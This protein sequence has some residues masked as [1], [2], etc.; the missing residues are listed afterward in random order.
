MEHVV[1]TLVSLKCCLER[2]H[3]SLLREVMDYFSELMKANKEE[4]RDAMG[5]DPTL[6]HE[7]EYDL[8]QYEKEFAAKQQQ[9]QQS[10]VNNLLPH[11]LKDHQ[12][13]CAASEKLFFVV[14]YLCTGSRAQVNE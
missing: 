7:I 8:Q 1:P 9:Q 2:A 11:E 4:V 13:R 10:Q 6:F 12:R 5:S 14:V 3:S